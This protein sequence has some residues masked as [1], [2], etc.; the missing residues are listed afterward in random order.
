M[1]NFWSDLSMIEKIY[2]VMGLAFSFFFLLQ[3]ILSLFGVDHDSDASGDADTSVDND[4]GIP[5]QF[6]TLKNMIAFFAIMGWTGLVCLRGG[7]EQWLAV[8][9]ALLAGLSM[10]VI[11]AAIFYFMSKLADQGNVDSLK[12]IGQTADVY[13]TIPPTRSGQGKISL[14][15]QGRFMEYQAI[16]NDDEAIP[17]GSQVTVLEITGSQIFIVTKI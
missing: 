8:L 12:A 3:M 16:T 17:T 5:F 4:A 9:I 1:G 10:M 7:M 6:F 13:L 2:A 15:V 14:K 11:M